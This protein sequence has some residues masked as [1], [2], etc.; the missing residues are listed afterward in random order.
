MNKMNNTLG[1]IYTCPMHPEV[2]SD[3]PGKCPKCGMSLVQKGKKTDHSSMDHGQEAK[4]AESSGL[5][6]CPMDPDV[7]SDKPGNCPKC[8]MKLVPMMTTEHGGH[9]EH[10]SME[11][12][13]RKRFFITLPFV[14]FTMLLS[15]NIQKWLS[16]T[17]DFSGRDIVLFVIGT[18]I[19]FFGGLP[20][21]KGA[22]GEI[23]RKNPQMMTLVAL[24]SA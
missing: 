4:H 2:T 16:L 7:I 9:E 24:L 23:S 20:F 15:P 19:F 18:F 14:V 5:Y 13:F 11:Y 3:K 17:L 22:A 12:E 6:T 21:F 10:A 1:K 8:G